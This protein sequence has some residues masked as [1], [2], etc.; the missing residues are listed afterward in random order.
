MKTREIVEQIRKG[1]LNEKTIGHMLIV[2]N[3]K[4]ESNEKNVMACNKNVEKL[5]ELMGFHTQ[6]MSGMGSWLKNVKAKLGMSDIKMESE[7]TM[8]LPEDVNQ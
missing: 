2:L 6:V 8:R 4:C 7:E 1:N 5:T 3:E